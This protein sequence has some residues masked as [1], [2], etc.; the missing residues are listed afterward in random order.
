[1]WKWN[2]DVNILRHVTL[3]VILKIIQHGSAQG[4]KQGCSLPLKVWLITIVHEE[5]KRTE[6]TFL[7]ILVQEDKEN[8]ENLL[9]GCE[10]NPTLW[11]SE[12]LFSVPF[13]FTLIWKHLF[14]NSWKTVHFYCAL[15]SL[16]LSFS[17]YKLW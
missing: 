4:N 2:T 16:N 1:M 12:E 5:T 15:F 13:Y 14:L 3:T 11:I 7:K 8:L 6:L 17:C 9:Y 10:M